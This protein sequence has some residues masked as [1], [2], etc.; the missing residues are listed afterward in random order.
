MHLDAEAGQPVV[1]CD[2]GLVGGLE[3]LNGPLSKRYTT[4]RNA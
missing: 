3:T 4:E 1:P 2:P